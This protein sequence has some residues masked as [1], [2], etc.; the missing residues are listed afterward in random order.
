MMHETIEEKKNEDENR[1]GNN[2]LN[3]FN[4][5]IYILIDANECEQCNKMHFNE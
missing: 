3:Q 4:Y 5:S 1:I 2:H